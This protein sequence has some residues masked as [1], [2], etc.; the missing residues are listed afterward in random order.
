MPKLLEL[1]KGTGSV[2]DAFERIGGWEVTSLDMVAKFKPTHVSN[3]LSFEYQQYPP[4]HFD[5]VWASRRALNLALRR[6]QARE[7]Y[8]AQRESLKRL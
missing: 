3:I 6:R 7:T 8:R 2:G 4:D 1:F 5:F